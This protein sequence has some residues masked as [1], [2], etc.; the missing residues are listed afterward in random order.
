MDDSVR[1]IERLTLA[2]GPSGFE[3]SVGCIVRESLA[4][5]GTVHTDPIG[6]IVCEITGTDPS[7]PVLLVAAHQDEIGFM[8]SD[9]LESGFLRFTNIGGWNPVTLPS[10]PVDVMDRE[11]QAVPGIIGQLP[12]HFLKKGSAV[13][14]PE[15]EDLFIDIGA[16]SAQEVEQVFG[17]SLGSIIIPATRFHFDERTGCIMSKAFD[18]RIGVAALVEL[19]HKLVETPV[20]STVLL[21][22]TVQEEVGTRGASSLSHRIKAD[23]ALVVEGAPADDV[24]GA[25][26]RAQTSVGKGVHVRIF[27]PTHIGHPAVLSLARLAAQKRAIMIQETVRKGGGTDA[28]V[29]A[30]ADRGIPAIVTGVPVRYAHSHNCLASLS[31][32]RSLVSLLH[33]MCQDMTKIA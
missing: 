21:A 12:P 26:A 10:S 25:P 19:G 1:L 8:V 6:N 2:A 5:I 11:G 31:D 15:L 16:S 27:D 29:L 7:A 24:P 17:I 32:Y 30:L 3:R 9:I 22:F 20:G 14:V 4:G 28:M 23:M 33:A 13:Q 18:D